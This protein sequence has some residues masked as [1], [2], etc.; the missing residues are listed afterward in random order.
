MKYNPG[1][2]AV[3]WAEQNARDSLF[4]AMRR[5]EAYATSGPR[6][7]SR[8]FGGWNFTPD[9][10]EAPDRVAIAYRSGVPMGG[11]LPA[12]TQANAAPTFLVAANQ[13]VGTPDS[14]GIPLQRIQII[15][16]WV[17][18]GERRERVIDV[19]GDASNGAAVDTATC[20]TSGTGFA[21][22]CAVWTD[23]EFKPDQQAYYYSRVVEN[24]TCRWSQ[25]MCAAAGVD[26]NNPTTIGRGYKPCCAQ[27]HR[28]IVQERAWSSPIWYTPPG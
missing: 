22:L 3:L 6:I 24:P 11:D 27:E 10:C 9:M 4:D 17:E 12:T 21:Q 1:G 13:D 16:S 8:F 26:C 23:E 20:E 15:K 7:V 19:A 25:R 28:P 14:P 2:L 18:Q 5:R